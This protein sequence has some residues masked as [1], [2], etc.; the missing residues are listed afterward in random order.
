MNSRKM[1]VDFLKHFVMSIVLLGFAEV[2]AQKT[3]TYPIGEFTNVNSSSEEQCADDP[4]VCGLLDKYAPKFIFHQN[5]KFLP[6]TVEHFL[7]YSTLRYRYSRRNTTEILGLGEVKESVLGQQIHGSE[8][9][10]T[11]EEIGKHQPSFRKSRSRGEYYVQVAKEH[12]DKVFRGLDPDTFDERLL[13][14]A[15]YGKLYKGEVLMG[16]QLQY[17][18][19]FPNNGSIGSHEGD[20]EGISVTVDLNGAFMYATYMSH[21]RSGTYL[22]QQIIFADSVGNEQSSSSEMPNEKFSHPVV[23]FSKAMH[24]TYPDARSRR[25]WKFIIPFPADKTKRGSI[26]NS[27]SRI[28]LLP[29]RFIAT[30][31][32]KWVQFAGRWGA[33]RTNW[34]N[35]PDAPPYKR[36]YYRGT[37]FRHKDV[38]KKSD[39]RAIGNEMGLVWGRLRFEPRLPN[40]DPDN[41]WLMMVSRNDLREQYFAEIYRT[42]DPVAKY[43]NLDLYNFDNVITGTT[44]CLQVADSYLTFDDINFGGEKRIVTSDTELSIYKT[45]KI[46][47]NDRIS[48]L[49]WEKCEQSNWV[50]FFRNNDFRGTSYFLNGE[51]STSVTD[52]EET[53]LGRGNIS[54]IRY[55]IPAGYKLVLYDQPDFTHDEFTIELRGTGKFSEIDFHL[56][57]TQMND[58]ISSAR[59]ISIA[60]FEN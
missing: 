30:G 27:H 14:Y 45:E 37:W 57:D 20:W 24:A 54:S 52:F 5:E 49:C 6:S 15:N 39:L 4:F 16:H 56:D 2:N 58:V 43:H 12:R 51:L 33:K 53:N 21:G 44:S 28:Q 35:S 1:L 10:L 17:W 22:P 59:I 25:K 60:P 19:F 11:V 50:S 38:K 46:E 18:L 13:C 41:R 48:S 40:C 9:S 36:P 55:C 3:I 47:D 42:D 32:M 29:N 34:F 26:F 8:G 23:F 7:K 31:K